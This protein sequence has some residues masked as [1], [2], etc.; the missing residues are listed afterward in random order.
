MPEQVE[1]K[2]LKH[3]DIHALA[4]IGLASAGIVHEIKNALQ[5]ISNAL[6]LLDTE[7]DL[8][9]TAREWIAVAQRELSHAFDVS[10]ET[11]ALVRE[12]NMTSL[13]VNDVLDDVL[14]NYAGKIAFKGMSV[15]RRYEFKE[16]I[17]A[18]P[19]A[20][21]QA[22]ANIILN[23]LECAPKQSG[24]LMI[25]THAARRVNGTDKRGV[26]ITF[27]DNGPGIPKENRKKVFRPL[28]STKKGKG[29]GLGLWITDK[30]IR[31]QHGG[32]RMRSSNKKSASG[33]CFSVFLPLNLERS[34]TKTAE[35]ESRPELNR[36]PAGTTI[37]RATSPPTQL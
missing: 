5:G 35:P 25:H 17:Q 29:T 30:L 3:P 1:R 32:L 16:T 14:E 23:A 36:K 20:V 12:E 13:K 19:G 34:S 21:R 31:K 22:F 27:L 11:L 9:P 24:K 2:Q 7:L 28:F 15:E 26:R 33:T 8:R 18:D 4:E 6:F 10:R 37:R